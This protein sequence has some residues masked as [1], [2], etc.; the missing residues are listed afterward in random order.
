MLVLRICYWI[1]SLI[2]KKKF[3]LGHYWELKG[4]DEFFHG[5]QKCLRSKQQ[6]FSIIKLI[7]LPSCSISEKFVSHTLTAD[8]YRGFCPQMLRI[9]IKRCMTRLLHFSHFSGEECLLTHPPHPNPR[10][11]MAERGITRDGYV[12]EH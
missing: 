3:C 6:R 2:F 9:K 12:V 5:L 10:K 1:K 11:V 7:L 4:Y 8:R